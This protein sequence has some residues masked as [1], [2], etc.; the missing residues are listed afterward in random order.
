MTN[1][2][3]PIEVLSGN[4][5]ISPLLLN[6]CG[7]NSIEEIREYLKPYYERLVRLYEEDLLPIEEFTDYRSGQETYGFD[8]LDSIKFTLHY[9]SDRWK[10]AF[11]VRWIIDLINPDYVLWSG[12]FNAN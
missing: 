11:R 1:K 10:C 6:A 7:M 5:D 2:R 3:F 9:I 8:D 4:G 12:H